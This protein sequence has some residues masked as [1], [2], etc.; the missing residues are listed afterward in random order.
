[1]GLTLNIKVHHTKK[2]LE[3]NI[4]IFD[5]KHD[6]VEFFQNFLDNVP[7]EYRIFDHHVLFN[8]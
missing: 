8:F 4:Y 5:L 6:H 3:V 2:L 1:M 7:A